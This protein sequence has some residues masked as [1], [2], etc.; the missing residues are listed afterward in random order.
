MFLPVCQVAS[1]VVKYSCIVSYSSQ[2]VPANC[3]LSLT[4]IELYARRSQILSGC[5]VVTS[6]MKVLK[7]ITHSSIDVICLRGTFSVDVASTSIM[8]GCGTPSLAGSSS[9]S[10]MNSL[11]Q[12]FL[13]SFLGIGGEC[14]PMEIAW[15][16]S[17]L[18]GINADRSDILFGVTV[19]VETLA[20]RMC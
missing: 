20:L 4:I 16:V 1:S 3:L 11:R 5:L 18:V 9:C 6:A 8:V 15:P 10:S 2:G 19:V 17:A 12:T 7:H 14:G 13:A